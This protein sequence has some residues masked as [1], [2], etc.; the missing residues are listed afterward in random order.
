MT[1][2]SGRSLSGTLIGTESNTLVL[3]HSIPKSPRLTIVR[4]NGT[5]VV[6]L[7]GAPV[8]T[9]VEVRDVDVVV[10]QRFAFFEVE[11]VRVV[12]GAYLGWG[13]AIA[14]VL[15]FLLVKLLQDVE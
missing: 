1:L 9:A 2:T 11:D 14:A 7:D 15:A 4:R 3:D 12:S 10:R 5:D 6:N 13:T 8:G